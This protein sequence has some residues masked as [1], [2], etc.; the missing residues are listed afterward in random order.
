M[1]VVDG[2]A[3]TRVSTVGADLGEVDALGVLRM[4]LT[5]YYGPEGQL[6]SLGVYGGQVVYWCCGEGG[7]KD[8]LVFGDKRF[9]FSARQN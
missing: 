5:H 3:F 6:V 1:L 7:R 9:A 4:S 2:E 8:R